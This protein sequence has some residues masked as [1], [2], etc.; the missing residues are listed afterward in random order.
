MKT[1]L[2]IDL[3]GNL[4]SRAR[5]YSQALSS[6]GRRGHVALRGLSSAAAAAGRGMDRLGN[7]YSAILGGAGVAM[8]V[9]GSA[10]LQERLVRLGITADASDEA[11]RDLHQRILDVANS[12][13]IR[14]DPS[15]ILTAVESIMEKTGDLKFAEA[16][17]RN[18]GLA[19]QS[20][21][22]EGGAIGDIFAEFQKQGM[23]SKEAL[24]SVD[25]LIAQGKA[26]AFTLKDLASLG[27]RVV[28]AYTALGRRGPQAMKEMGAVL[29]LI[30]MGTGSSEQAATSW[31]AMLRTFSDKKKVAFLK[32]Q[33][34]NLF[35]K[36]GNLR[37]VNELMVEILRA[38]KNKATNLSDV[39]DAEAIRAFNAIL[40]E[41]KRTGGAETLNE[42]MRIT[43]DGTT[44]QKDSARAARTANAA[45]QSLQTTW[46]KFA[47]TNLAGPIEKVTAALDSIEPGKLEQVLNTA[48]KAALAMGGV[49]AAYKLVRGGIAVRD[50]VR[51]WGRGPVGTS[52]AGAALPGLGLK[53]P[54]PVYVVNKQMS[55]TRDAMLGKDAGTVLPE[56]G[57]GNGGKGAKGK[58]ATLPGGRRARIARRFGRA[59]GMGMAAA[60]AYGA[61]EIMADDQATIGDKAGAI[62]DTAGQ[63]AGGWAG[64][65][66]GAKVGASIGTAIAPGLG[67][68]IGGALGGVVGGIA[69]SGLAQS[70]T[71]AVK[72][73]LGFGD[74]KATDPTSQQM[75][76]AAETMQSAAQQ[77][78][79]A[80]ANG[81]AVDVNVQGNAQATLRRG[82]G[83]VYSGASYAQQIA[84]E[85]M[86]D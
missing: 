13:D 24:A 59:G 34:I 51:G 31:E 48:G 49:V 83:S 80:T 32:K 30:R 16:N 41:L 45:W 39:F 15:Q 6:L 36:Q 70:L 20:A 5:Q 12:P 62:V 81:V 44:V 29:Q 18:I 28:T 40:G 54:L 77:L 58:S 86:G 85:M 79:A 66:L 75:Q 3:A 19:M 55:L 82:N 72:G 67:T 84:S 38:A 61:Y 52:K 46:T 73:W 17:I 68:A 47:D 71:N 23:S 64:A 26:G 37:A 21:G 76:R 4:Q 27:P 11:V 69:G 33:G 35:D 7:R 25:T 43:G 42:L 74:N 60:T 65:A 63:A 56:G 10:N 57:A 8:A 14:A 2:I 1:S 22:A 78:A 9:R 50:S 53:L